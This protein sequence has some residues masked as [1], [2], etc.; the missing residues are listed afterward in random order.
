M[1]L[2]VS[3][4][5]TSDPMFGQQVHGT[6]LDMMWMPVLPSQSGAHGMMDVY[7]RVLK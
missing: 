6:L 2:E 7:A 3:L 1:M 5:G 4:P